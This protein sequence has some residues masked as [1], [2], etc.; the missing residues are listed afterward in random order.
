MAYPGER[1]ADLAQ[2]GSSGGREMGRFMKFWNKVC[3]TWMG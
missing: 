1:D 3:R 2:G